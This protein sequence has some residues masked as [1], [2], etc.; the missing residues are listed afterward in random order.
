MNMETTVHAPYCPA[1]HHSHMQGQEVVCG[2]FNVRA[3]PL[4]A[5]DCTDFEREPG[6]DDEPLVFMGEGRGWEVG[7]VA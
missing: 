7:G 1:C 2:M 3:T 4:V 6:S 5:Q